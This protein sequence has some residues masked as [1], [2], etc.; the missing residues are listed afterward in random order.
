MIFHEPF[1]Y[2]NVFKPLFSLGLYSSLYPQIFMGDY[3]PYFIKEVES[4]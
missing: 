2:N 3:A 4:V 1:L